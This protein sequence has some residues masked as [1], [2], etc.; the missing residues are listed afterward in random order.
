MAFDKDAYKE[1]YLRPKSRQRLTALPD[2]LF[3]RYAITLPPKNDAEIA[4]TVKAV[5]SFWS[6]QQPGTPMHK[7]AKMCIAA[8]EDLKQQKIESGSHKGKDMLTAAWW[9]AKRAEADNAAKD[10]IKNLASLLKD[11]N[12]AF[13][14][15]TR[16]Y[17]ATCADRL[18]LDPAQAAQA[19]SEAK[20]EVVDDVEI[21]S[22]PPVSEAQYRA[23]E[24]Y[25]SVGQVSSVPE[26]IHPGCRPF[27]IVTR[28]DSVTM[29]AA[30]L[31]VAAVR[32]QEMDAQKKAVSANWDARRSALNILRSEAE[33]GAD[34]RKISLYHLASAVI[35][36]SVPGAV[37]IKA[38]L[39]SRGVDDH[40]ASI[41]AVV[42]ADR[43]GVA[44]ETGS[45][46]VGKLLEEG[47]LQEAEAVAQ[48][49]PMDGSDTIKKVLARVE[50]AK[51]K[52][53]AL[54][55]EARKLL[56]V[57]DEIG[58]AAKVREAAAISSDDAEATMALVPLAPPRDLRIDIDGTAVRLL[59]Q[60]NVGHDGDTA[61]TVVR[62]ID[63]PPSTLVNGHPLPAPSGTSA[64]DDSAPVARPVH[65][66]VFATVPGRPT[67][68][69]ASG[70][71]V[72]VPAVSDARMETGP[73][74]VSAHW[75]IH[76]RAHHVE[77][78]RRDGGTATPIEVRHGSARLSRL[79]EGVSVHVELTTV[80]EKPEGGWLRSAPVVVA[81]TPRAAAK[82]LENLRAQ[83]IAG[84][85]GVQVRFTWTPI[86]RSEVRL[87][88]NG[89]AARWSIG[90]MVTPEEMT[91]WGTDVTGPTDSA[92]GQTKL[93]ST[94]PP[95]VHY[96]TPFSVGGT[97]IVVGRSVSVGVTDPVSGLHATPFSGFARLA[98]TWPDTSN[99]VE[100]SWERDDAGADAVGL[101]KFSRAQYT[102]KG[103][104]VPL[105]SAPCEVAVRALMVVGGETFASPPATV[106][107]STV[108]QSKIHYKVAS[109]GFGPVGGRSKKLILIAE[110]NAGPVRIAL[111]A[112]PG[113][114]MPMQPDD[115]L[116]IFEQTISFAAG[117]SQTFPASVPK[118][119][120]KPYWIRCFVL[121]GNAQLEDPPL[122]T[123]KEG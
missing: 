97:G 31:D 71:T 81:G 96:V 35:G 74:W 115:G 42:L 104:T 118:A 106:T 76:P 18:S 84:P 83:P 25:M 37:G 67:S 110:E 113:V 86:D 46:R 15:V 26:L 24:G 64:T 89:V 109:S 111:V 77:A 73:D 30:N 105:G 27:R 121:S 63:A 14:V 119:I 20:L 5:R 108:S 57:P 50:A 82:P 52:L 10:R 62:S 6:S 69:P 65:Y 21:P 40:D 12:G 11:S 66:S 55:D 100:V 95:G 68:R 43:A 7:F 117:V 91:A 23:L 114:F 80:Y 123:L 9:E 45:A 29:P 98:W 34:L 13:G 54:L 107:I 116:T 3:E 19:A 60:P 85:S 16:S 56:A 49:L 92:P 53:A 33:R 103:V 8:D 99:L 41:L 101:E 79:P 61:Y 44:S 1:S 39:K 70:Q 36:S 102:A 38:E 2:D 72:L 122:N 94:I 78:V 51:A 58:A 47:R 120:S 59:W 75:S 112:A 28:F 87:R 88:R 4:G 48:G 17:L 93:E 90:E 22:D 32:T